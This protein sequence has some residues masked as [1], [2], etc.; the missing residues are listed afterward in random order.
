[1]KEKHKS[2]S[3]TPPR[4]QCTQTQRV[5][6][7]I[8]IIMSQYI[9]FPDTADQLIEIK[10]TIF[11]VAP[12]IIGAIYCTHIGLTVPSPDPFPFLKQKLFMSK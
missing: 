10:S 6:K 5:L 12:N 11:A 8:N 2:R 9:S 1:M 7:A 4:T 3:F